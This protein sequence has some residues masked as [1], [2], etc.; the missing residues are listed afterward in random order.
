MPRSA[1]N[2]KQAVMALL[3]MERPSVL[4]REVRHQKAF[5]TESS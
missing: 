4:P 3:M 1:R 2:S 5:Y